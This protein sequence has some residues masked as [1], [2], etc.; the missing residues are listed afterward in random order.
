MPLQ[1]VSWHSRPTQKVRSALPSSWQCWSSKLWSWE[2]PPS[3]VKIWQYKAMQSFCIKCFRQWSLPTDSRSSIQ[4]QHLRNHK[5]PCRTILA[6]SRSPL[7]ILVAIL[8]LIMSVMGIRLFVCHPLGLKSAGYLW[9][10]FAWC[11]SSPSL[12]TPLMLNSV[13][14]AT[15]LHWGVSGHAPVEDVAAKL[16]SWVAAVTVMSCQ[17]CHGPLFCAEARGALSHSHL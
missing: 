1:G 2:Q 8:W 13:H 9:R 7:H 12:H 16:A 14:R 17:Q 3:P 10:S 5:L 4:P 15:V 11:F 6:S